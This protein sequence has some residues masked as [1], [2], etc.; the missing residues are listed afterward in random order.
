MYWITKFF[1]VWKNVIYLSLWR[2]ALNWALRLFSQR[3]R[4]HLRCNHRYGSLRRRK[5][6]S[7][8]N[9]FHFK[10]HFLS[11][12]FFYIKINKKDFL[13]QTFQEL[14]FLALNQEELNVAENCFSS[15][16]CANSKKWAPFAAAV[17]VVADNLCW[18]SF[19]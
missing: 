1:F 7:G 19:S 2:E 13:E 8:L 14:L 12:N 11:Y 15:I 4:K 9:F 5:C 16:V 10:K 6:S 3:S 17:K 18:A